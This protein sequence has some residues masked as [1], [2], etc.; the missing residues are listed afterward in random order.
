MAKI[1]KRSLFGRDAVP[2]KCYFWDRHV[3][4]LSVQV[5]KAFSEGG[6]NNPPADGTY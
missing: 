5:N 1:N 3:L 6:K 4:S 2:L